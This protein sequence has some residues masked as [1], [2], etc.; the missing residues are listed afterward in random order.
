MGFAP[1]QTFGQHPSGVD[2]LS[3]MTEVGGRIFEWIM[4]FLISFL[5]FSDHHQKQMWGWVQ[6]EPL[7]LVSARI[8]GF[9]HI[10]TGQKMFQMFLVINRSWPWNVNALNM[11]CPL[12]TFRMTIMEETTGHELFRLVMPANCCLQ[13]MEACRQFTWLPDRPRHNLCI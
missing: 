3:K 2:A 5:L 4:R 10:A 9:V 6:L 7:R 1:R 13:K 8:A 12:S 11:A